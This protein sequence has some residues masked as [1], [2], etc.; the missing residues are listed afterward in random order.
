MKIKK[1]GSAV[2]QGGL[3]DGRGAISTESGALKSYPYG[4]ASRFEG[5]PGTNPEELIG[6]AHAGC[7]TMALSLILGEAKLRAEHMDSKAEVA[8][9]QV[10]GGYAITSVRLTLKAKIPGVDQRQFEEL[11]GKAKAGCPVSKLLKADITLDA[12]LIA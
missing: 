8:L 5:Q 1:S 10:E 11:A 12:D 6:A 3:K 7:F 9:E 2:W 4:F